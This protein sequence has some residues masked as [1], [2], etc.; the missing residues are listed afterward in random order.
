MTTQTPIIEMTNIAKSFA[1][2][3]ALEGVS[4]AVR[5][6][7]VTCVLGDN[8]AGKSTLIKIMGGF[9]YYDAGAM[10]VNGVEVRFN[11][12]REAL[13]AGIATVYQDLAVVDLME[14][15]R[16]FFLGSEIRK[17]VPVL[18]P[19][20]I[21]RMRDTTSEEL[22]KLG[23][24]LDDVNQ[25][26]GTLSGGQRQCVA[27]ARAVYFGA[28]VLILDEPTASLGVHQSGVVLKYVAKARESGI[29]VVFI[30][31]NPHHAYL[32]GDHFA[33]L[34]LGRMRLDAK[35]EDITVDQLVREMAGGDDLA[36]LA[37]ELD[38]SGAAA[39]G[40]AEAIDEI[41]GR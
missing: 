36:A 38:R 33:V 32:I 26:L 25:P 20:D 7:E 39:P 40:A 1:H 21:E 28:K 12:P 34:K 6:G 27:I 24:H 9:H 19:M 11:S 10:K 4:L 13:N 15:W 37:H 30:T 8:G 2:V 35:R 17:S 16:N 22:A 3:R 31:H 18:K 23:I 41:K 29:G 14:T 5:S